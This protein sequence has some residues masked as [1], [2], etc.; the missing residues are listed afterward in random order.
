M[1]KVNLAVPIAPADA[2]DV[3]CKHGLEEAK[4]KG[5]PV[6]GSGFERVAAVHIFLD[7]GEEITNR[8]TNVSVTWEQ[9]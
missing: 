8:I 9:G 7:S 5:I 4:A 6:P 2:L 3:L 1:S